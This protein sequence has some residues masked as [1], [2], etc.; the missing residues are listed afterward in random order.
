MAISKK[1]K[2]VALFAI[3][4]VIGIYFIYKA[5]KKPTAL[6]PS[7][8]KIVN[9]DGS[10]TYVPAS[11]PTPIVVP[12]GIFPLKYGSKGDMVTKLQKMMNDGGSTLKV[13]G[14]FGILT[15]G[16]V[17]EWLGKNTV[18]SQ[19]DWNIIY[20][21]VYDTILSNPTLVPD[22]NVPPTPDFNPFNPNGI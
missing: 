13:D 4:V 17:Y 6:T 11:K 19:D 18:D 2:I 5:Y 3:P 1:T 22:L 16:Q 12:N 7:S 15:Q 21:N 10:V 8:N 9:P 20:S 14:K